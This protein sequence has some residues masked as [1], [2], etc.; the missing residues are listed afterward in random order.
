M[1]LQVY[2]SRPTIKQQLNV[3]AP[4]FRP[5]RVA[6]ATPSSFPQSFHKRP[7]VQ[8]WYASQKS[9]IT[10][11]LITYK[12][13]T[14]FLHARHVAIY[15]SNLLKTLKWTPIAQESVCPRR[16][17]ALLEHVRHN[18]GRHQHWNER[19]GYLQWPRSVL[20]STFPANLVPRP[21]G[22][23]KQ[24]DRQNDYSSPD[25]HGL[26]F[27]QKKDKT[28]VREGS[29]LKTRGSSEPVTYKRH[30]P[31]QCWSLYWTLTCNNVNLGI[32]LMEVRNIAKARRKNLHKV[33]NGLKQQQTL[34]FMS[35]SSKKKT[36]L[37]SYT[38]SNKT[39]ERYKLFSD[40][41]KVWM[42]ACAE[43]MQEA[44]IEKHKIG[45]EIVGETTTALENIGRTAWGKLSGM[46]CSW[47]GRKLQW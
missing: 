16:V 17:Y 31:N 37:A 14:S 42:L 25:G 33:S 36:Q 12:D 40:V 29:S 39:A 6:A 27:S 34:L 13:H 10:S 1:E 30:N 45:T 21:S 46:T 9:S 41:V 38:V 19:E 32:V 3:Q 24:S 15:S 8:I 5:R 43:E 18:F 28:R 26:K 20:M 47:S 4:E 7:I 44:I 22:N 23:K 2:V 35:S 11:K